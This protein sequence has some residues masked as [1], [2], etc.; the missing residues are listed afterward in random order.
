MP[1][2]LAV[3]GFGVVAYT[4]PRSDIDSTPT[5]STSP[6][7]V[8]ATGSV[9]DPPVIFVILVVLTNTVVAVPLS[10][11]Q[12]AINN[13]KAAKSPVNNLFVYIVYKLKFDIIRCNQPLLIFCL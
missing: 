8:A 6:P 1:L 9:E 12:P 13:R 5:R 4:T 11:L 3:V 7:L 2:L 10:F